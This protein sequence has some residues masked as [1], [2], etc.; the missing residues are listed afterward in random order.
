MLIIASPQKMQI[1]CL[2]LKREGKTIAIVPTMGFLH[3]GHLRLID[4]ARQAADVVVLT[5]FVNPMQFG[6]KEDFKK[7]PRSI[8]D[9]LKKARERDVDYIFM[10]QTSAMYPE[11]YQT[12]VEVTQAS[13]HLC[14]VSRLGHFRGVATVVLKL[15]HIVMPDVAVFG[16]KDFQ[17]LAVI[18]AMVKDLNL[19]VRVIGQP[20]VREADGLAMSSRNVYLDDEQRAAALCLSRGLKNVKA[21]VNK[22]EASIPQLLNALRREIRKEKIARIDYAACMN[23]ATIQPISHY[24]PHRTLFAVAVFIGRTRLI[25]NVVV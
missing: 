15:F 3:E 4:R 10:P 22:G 8:R 25:D 2:G 24:L 14:G 19:P 9:D 11:G 18:R 20:I 23:A 5:I 17:Q 12:F 6:P 21:L 13:Q 16:K 1:L 7:Y